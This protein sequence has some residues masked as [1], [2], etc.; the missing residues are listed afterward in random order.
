MA[1]LCCTCE[2]C[3]YRVLPYIDM[4]RHTWHWWYAMAWYDYLFDHLGRRQS[5]SEPPMGAR[6]PPC[7]ASE[8]LGAKVG[9]LWDRPYGHAIPFQ[10]VPLGLATHSLVYCWVSPPVKA[11]HRAQGLHPAWDLSRPNSKIPRGRGYHT[12]AQVFVTNTVSPAS[13]G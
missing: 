3:S 8:G 12:P 1:S 6:I 2:F 9:P 13:G 4:G 7:G 5:R 10:V 11:Y